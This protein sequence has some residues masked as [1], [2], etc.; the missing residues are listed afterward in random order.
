MDI[1][2]QEA[3]TLD[4]VSCMVDGVVR[5]KVIDPSSAIF[6]VQKYVSQIS[7][8]SNSPKRCNW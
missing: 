1:P 7:A 4:N 6:K 2:T 5:F 8:K 3:I